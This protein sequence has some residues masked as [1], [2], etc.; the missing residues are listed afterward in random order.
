MKNNT[1]KH[2][3]IILIV[4]LIAALVTVAGS[5]GSIRVAGWPLFAL[6]AVLAFVIQWLAFIPAWK[7]QTEKYFDLTGSLTFISLILLALLLSPEPDTRSL[8]LAMLVS[9]WAIRLGSFLFL[10]IR[11]DGS[12]GRF[13][14]IKPVFTRF[15]LT[16]TLQGLWVF[17]TMS[18]ALVA[19]TSSERE[20][21][22][23]FA[24]AGL[25]VWLSGFS[26]EVI[27]DAQKRQFRNDPANAGKFINT[28]L[29]A[30]SRH[31]NYFGEILLWTGVTLIAVPVLSGL[32]WVI[33]IS[34]V[35]VTL[36]LTRVS[37]I[38]LL[39]ARAARRWGNDP[40]Y[41]QYLATTPRLVPLPRGRSA[42]QP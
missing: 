39:E 6:C 20:P 10:R 17:L 11:K 27:A 5:Q 28:G 15:L 23:F 26:L 4:L 14:E 1:I 7:A 37:G 16:W 38:P 8:L 12:D 32:Q 21:L 19:I 18:A 35:F 24:F 31:P 2:L 13:D 29:W 9:V 36:L 3:L 40:E 25:L 33:I 41:Q 34:P 30:W 22:E 42:S